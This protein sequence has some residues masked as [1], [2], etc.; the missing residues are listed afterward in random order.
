MAL[1]GFRRCF[2]DVRLADIR[3]EL[4]PG[5]RRFLDAGPI[6]RPAVRVRPDSLHLGFVLAGGFAAYG[7][8]INLSVAG[9]NNLEVLW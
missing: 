5:S 7:G 4:G 8:G 9:A 2:W 1:D 3:E 6:K